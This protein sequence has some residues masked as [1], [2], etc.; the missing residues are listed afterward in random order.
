VQHVLDGGLWRIWG[1]VGRHHGRRV[2]VPCVFL[3]LL[4]NETSMV[5]L[6]SAGGLLRQ[7]EE[8]LFNV[9]AL[10]VS[11]RKGCAGKTRARVF[12]H[13]S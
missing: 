6:F 11:S 1:V 10:G 8:F 4:D 13:H 2:A 5:V 9:E 7:R 3:Y 12:W